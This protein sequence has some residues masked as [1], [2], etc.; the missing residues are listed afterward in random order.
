MAGAAMNGNARSEVMDKSK[1]SD[2][3]ITNEARA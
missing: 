2:E 3:P 1:A